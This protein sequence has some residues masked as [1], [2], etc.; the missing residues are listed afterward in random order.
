MA[1]RLKPKKPCLDTSVFIGGLSGE[2]CNGVKRGVIFSRLWDRATNGDFPIYISALVIAE[3]FAKPGKSKTPEVAQRSFLQLIEHPC[4]EVVEVDRRTGL[5]AHRLCSVHTRDRLRPGDATHLAAAIYAGCDVLLAWDGPLVGIQDSRIRIEEP[6]IYEPDLFDVGIENATV[7]EILEYNEHGR[8]L[9][10]IPQREA[11]GQF[12]EGK[13]RELDAVADSVVNLWKG[14][15][16]PSSFTTSHARKAMP[17]VANNSFLT[18]LS[19]YC[20]GGLM[21]AK[22]GRTARFIKQE[23]GLFSCVDTTKRGDPK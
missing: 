7:E 15:K 5:E 17:T 21:V 6:A 10:R 4:V 11:T 3:V 18:L 13:R 9:E 14:G 23:K 20:E 22:F 12:Q 1:E 19:D 16:L 8:K 2:I